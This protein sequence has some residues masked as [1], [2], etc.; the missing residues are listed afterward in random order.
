MTPEKIL[1]V[2]AMYEKTL[3]SRNI[4]K[5]RMDPS[6]TFQ[7]LNKKQRLAHAHYLCD[8]IK[9][10]AHDRDKYGKLNRHFTAIQMCLSFAGAYTLEELMNHNRED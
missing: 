5:K 9:I 10:F 8:G 3:R 4:P 6:Q 7:S 1:F 2:V